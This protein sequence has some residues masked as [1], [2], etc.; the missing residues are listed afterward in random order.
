MA[1]RKRGRRRYGDGPADLRAE[2]TRYSEQNAYV[3]QH[4]ADAVCRCGAGTF[5]LLLDDEEG[6][7]VRRCVSCSAEHSI[8][9]SGEYLADAELAE[10]ACPCG[11][12]QFEVTAG[13]SL[14]GRTEDVRWLYLGCRCV[15]CGLV[16]VYGDWKCE[17]EG[18]RGLLERV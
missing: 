15:A 3:A 6:A 17:Y 7:A 11:G 8:G 1:L 4:F 14:Y 18:Y 2:I 12:D 10:C 5:R 13:V 9:D 16:A